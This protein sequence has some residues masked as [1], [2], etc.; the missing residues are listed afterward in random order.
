MPINI[1]LTLS[2]DSGSKGGRW[3]ARCEMFAKNP[4]PADCHAL[5]S[6]VHTA[7]GPMQDARNLKAMAERYKRLS[8]SLFDRR[9]IAVVLSCARELEEHAKALGES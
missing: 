3:T 8:E 6:T 7:A 9:V 4:D 1:F 2:R 5:N